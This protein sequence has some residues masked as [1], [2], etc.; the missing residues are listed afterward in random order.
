MHWHRFTVGLHLK[1]FYGWNIIR[2]VV[3]TNTK[4]VMEQSG[5][6]R[7]YAYFTTH[8]KFKETI[9]SFIQMRKHTVYTKPKQNSI[10]FSL[11]YSFSLSLYGSNHHTL[12]LLIITGWNKAVPLHTNL[13]S[14][15]F[16]IIIWL[17]GSL[18][19]FFFTVQ[20]LLSN[21]PY[22]IVFNRRI[23]IKYKPPCIPHKTIY[24][25]PC[26]RVW[27]KKKKKCIYYIRMDVCV[28]VSSICMICTFFFY[29]VSRSILASSQWVGYNYLSLVHAHIGAM[30]LKLRQNTP[31]RTHTPTMQHIDMNTNV[32]HA[33]TYMR[34]AH[35]A[36]SSTD[37]LKCHSHRASF[38]LP[39]WG[40]GH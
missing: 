13:H 2:P 35:T 18:F 37:G 7:L 36:D 15:N 39:A 28:C 29:N 30:A 3:C 17:F 38:R 1:S 22:T 14:V 24:R 12:V 8:Q 40:Y 31:T 6:V 5:I 9:N 4:L 25:H 26:T 16:E 10:Y 33:H 21:G 27:V 23:L 34:R 11:S 32:Q 19:T 20:H